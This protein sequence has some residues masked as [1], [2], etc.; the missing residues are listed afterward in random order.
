MNTPPESRRLAPPPPAGDVKTPPVPSAPMA[1]KKIAEP[2]GLGVASKGDVKLVS[3]AAT[4][5]VSDLPVA[6]GA[7]IATTFPGTAVLGATAAFRVIAP[8]GAA[9]VDVGANAARV[10]PSA[11]AVVTVFSV[12]ATAWER[13][14]RQEPGSAKRGSV[15]ES[16]AG[17]YALVVSHSIPSRP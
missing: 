11:P 15:R 14:H 9:G 13:A 5:M 4:T 16:A 6:A 10:G 12:A 1:V 8:L 17:A 2:S 3:L 7:A